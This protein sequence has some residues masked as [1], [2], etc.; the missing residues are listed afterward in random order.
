MS[1]VKVKC[2]ETD[3]DWVSEEA[4]QE[5]AKFFLEAHIKIKHLPVQPLHQPV[6]ATLPRNHPQSERVKRPI[7]TFT[8]QTLEQEDYEHFQY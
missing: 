2:V 8:G 4:E 6:A 1:K 3:C 5:M 7:L